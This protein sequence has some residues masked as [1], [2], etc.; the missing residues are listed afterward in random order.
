VRAA[1]KCISYWVEKSLG[2]PNEIKESWMKFIDLE[3]Q[4]S[5]IRK[6]IE[7][8]IKAVLDHGEYIMGPEV[9]ELEEKL[10]ELAGVKH[11]IGV[12]SGTDALLMS[13]MAIGVGAGDEVI[14][15]AFS[16]IATAEVVKLLGATLVF[17]DVNPKYY[18]MD[19]HALKQAITERTK[20][21]I[22]VGMPM[23]GYDVDYEAG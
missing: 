23:R 21:I 19:C 9:F 8:R 1:G 20:A 7:S 11:C 6:N 15:P 10:A 17:V 22:P 12:S 16:F 5:R 13:L 14:V 18:T 4:Q 2:L 3:R